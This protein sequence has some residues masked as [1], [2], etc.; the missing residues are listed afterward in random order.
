MLKSYGRR[1][2]ISITKIDPMSWFFGIITLIFLIFIC[3]V[4]IE[5]KGSRKNE[6]IFRKYLEEQRMLKFNRRAKNRLVKK[7]RSQLS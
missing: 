7:K 1:V 3:L 2:V 5:I 6:Q 4:F